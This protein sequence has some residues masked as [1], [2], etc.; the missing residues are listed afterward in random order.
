MKPQGLFRCCVTALLLLTS[1]TAVAQTAHIERAD[2]QAITDA[3]ARD[4]AALI[5]QPGFATAVTGALA[6]RPDGVPLARVMAR[7]DPQTR[8]QCLAHAGRPGSPA[9]AEKRVA[10]RG[11]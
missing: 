4:V 6:A 7:F 9:A 11:R 2:V 5:A 3:S 10:R 1:A 8:T